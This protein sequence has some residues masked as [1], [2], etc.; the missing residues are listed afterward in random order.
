VRDSINK[1]IRL[2]LADTDSHPGPKR[3]G[4]V[5]F[6]PGSQDG[7]IKHLGAQSRAGRLSTAVGANDDIAAIDHHGTDVLSDLNQ[8]LLPR[9][10]ALALAAEPV[11]L[12]T[13]S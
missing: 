6:E 8:A 7:R 5:A 13:D 1:G 12:A 3:P 2:P 11:A 4:Q 10:V 9:Q